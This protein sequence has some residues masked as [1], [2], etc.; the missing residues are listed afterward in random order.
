MLWREKRG[1]KKENQESRKRHVVGKRATSGRSPSRLLWRTAASPGS[2]SMVLCTC[3]EN[4]AAHSSSWRGYFV[5]LPGKWAK[6]SISAASEAVEAIEQ[7]RG[8]QVDQEVH[9]PSWQVSVHGVKQRW[10]RASWGK[11]A[12]WDR[13][14]GWRLWPS[15]QEM[16]RSWRPPP[17][18]AALPV[19][20]E[21]WQGLHPEATKMN[22]SRRWM[23]LNYLRICNLFKL[24]ILRIWDF[25]SNSSFERKV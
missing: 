13:S 14:T 15:R 7:S 19:K 9:A 1:K 22:L 17:Q 10:R 2:R 4:L 25:F 8:W 11:W 5:Y 18:R 3:R 6:V 16:L 24:F 23:K 12:H 21:T 20:S